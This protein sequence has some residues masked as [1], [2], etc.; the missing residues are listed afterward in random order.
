MKGSPALRRLVY[1]LIF[2]AGFATYVSRLVAS[3]GLHE[4]PETG[5]GHDYDAIAYNVWHGR[6]FG[7]DWSDPDWRR[8]YEGIPR[9]RLLL[10]RQSDFYPTT[11]RPPAMPLLLS[12]LYAVVGRTFAAWR[13]LNCGIMAGALTIAA[14]SSAE[15]AGLPAAVLT[16]LLALQSRD[17]AR[18]A[19]LFMTEPLATLMLAVVT[20]TWIVSARDGWTTRRAVASGA[21]LGGLLAARTIFILTIPVVLVL[22][23]RDRSRQSPFAWKMK[24]ICLV[25]ALLVIGPW[26]IRNTIVLRAFMPLGTQGGSICRWGS[27]R[28]RLHTAANGR[29]IREMGGRKSRRSTWTRSRPK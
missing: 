19:T 17:L 14:M 25:V 12:G 28:G 1:V 26:W 4:P 23:G 18:F 29:R 21:A 2:V 20:W 13:I 3:G 27:A 10:S 7:Y 11:Y 16:L 9:Y 24:A 15:I 22:P 6:G 8:P 5:D